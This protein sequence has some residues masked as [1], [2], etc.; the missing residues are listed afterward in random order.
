M[1]KVIKITKLTIE[2]KGDLEEKFNN[3]AKTDHRSKVS[4]GLKLLEVGLNEV[5]KE[6]RP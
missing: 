3:W 1:V 6:T 2:V 4:A 5:L